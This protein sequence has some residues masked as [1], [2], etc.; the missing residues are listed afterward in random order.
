M[1][2]AHADV[3][4]AQVFPDARISGGTVRDRQWKSRWVDV[5]RILE[6]RDPI[7]LVDGFERTISVRHDQTNSFR[8]RSVG[9]CPGPSDL[10]TAILESE[11]HGDDQK[12]GESVERAQ[13]LV[14]QIFGGVEVSDLRDLRRAVWCGIKRRRPRRRACAGGQSVGK[15]AP[16][17][18]DG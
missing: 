2:V 5:A 18:A 12:L 11:A 9:R 16:A 14:A 10:Q 1:T 3:E 15:G 7:E 17:H 6:N 4:S 8:P 13:S